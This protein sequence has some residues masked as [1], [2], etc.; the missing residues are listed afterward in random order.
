M[1]FVIL[2]K[3]SLKININNIHLH[4][5]LLSGLFPSCFSDLNMYLYISLITCTE[6]LTRYRT[7]HF[8]NNFTTNED[9]A[10]K[11]E[12]GLTSL[13]TKC[14]DIITCA[15]NG[16]HLLTDRIRIIKEMPSSVAS[17]TLSIR[18]TSPSHPSV[19]ECN[20]QIILIKSYK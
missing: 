8:F 10:M 18:P 9:I 1:T 2:P 6:C 4:L 14:D 11:F 19:L 5:D 16:H 13:C 17:G 12:T 3:Y 15:V 7:R 20:T